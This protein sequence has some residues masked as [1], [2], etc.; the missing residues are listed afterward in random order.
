[1]TVPPAPDLAPV[2]LPTG[3][4]GARSAGIRRF[5]QPPPLLPLFG[6][7]VATARLRHGSEIA[8]TSFE[9]VE[10]PIDGQRLAAY[11]RV[12]GFRVGDTLPPTFLHVVAFPLAV[13]RM[14]A[15]DFPFPLMGLVHVGNAIVQR[16]PVRLGESVALSVRAGDLRPH[17]AGTQFDVVAE[18]YAADGLVWTGRSTYLRRG[19]VGDRSG[20]PELPPTAGPIA[21]IRVDG[22]IG[23]RYAAVAGDVN[24]IHLHSLAAK[25][26]GFRRAIAHG[27]WLTARVLASLEGRLPPSF[28]VEVAFKTPVFLPSTV[29]LSTPRT[30]GGWT[31][32]VRSSAGRPHLAGTIT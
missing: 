14:T 31:L 24:P 8:P 1:M 5:A 18:A 30:A 2:T 17:A 27:M 16:R 19:P 25:A 15:P 12:C 20:R 13:A 29:L 7:A 11:Q 22:D 23:R 32:D 21:R 4:D 28:T 3:A 6:R 10:R 9:L 26:L